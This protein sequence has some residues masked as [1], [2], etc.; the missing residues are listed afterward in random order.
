MRRLAVFIGVL[1]LATACMTQY[2]PPHRGRTWACGRWR[3]PAGT[4]WPGCRAAH[5]DTQV[6][7]R[8]ATVASDEIRVLLTDTDF[9]TGLADPRPRPALRVLGGSEERLHTVVDR[10][11]P[12]LAVKSAPVPIPEA[13]GALDYQHTPGPA[14]GQFFDE[15]VQLQVLQLCSLLADQQH[16]KAAHL[17]P[18]MDGTCTADEPSI[19][20]KVGETEYPADNYSARIDGRPAVLGGDRVAVRLRDDLPYNL[21]VTMARRSAGV[22]ET[23]VPALL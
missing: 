3:R 19:T 23:L 20:V 4:C 7:G 1:A 10:I 18:R 14:H 2:E 8:P 16:V 5:Y 15:P 17:H 9:P 6:A 13:S 21:T 22:A 11:V 12:R